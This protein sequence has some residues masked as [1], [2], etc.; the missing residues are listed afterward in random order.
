MLEQN[1]KLEGIIYCGCFA[2]TICKMRSTRIRVMLVTDWQVHT[3]V[4]ANQSWFR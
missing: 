2:G 4:A 1:K 3:L